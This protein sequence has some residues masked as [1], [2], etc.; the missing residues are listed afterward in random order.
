VQGKRARLWIAEE[1]Q[2]MD[3]VLAMCRHFPERHVARGEA[4]IREGQ[5]RDRMY[6]LREGAFEVLRQ[7]VVVVRINTPGPFL[8]EISAVLGV[9]PSASVLATRDS[10]VHEIDAASEEVRRNPE[11]TLAI[12]QLLA[13]RLLAVTA[14]LVDIKRQYAGNDG[15][16]SLMDRVL[17][18]LVSTV[19]PVTMPLGS[20]RQ[21]VPDY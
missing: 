5:A 17:G 12:A 10:R 9:V 19:S 15:H 1:K 8:G 18:D 16:L 7:G 20:E 14:Y 4:L 11:L 3:D 13:R 21:D 6:V 2:A